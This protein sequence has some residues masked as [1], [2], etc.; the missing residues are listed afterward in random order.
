VVAV[1]ELLL[2]DAQVAVAQPLAGVPDRARHGLD[3]WNGILQRDD[4]GEQLA[5]VLQLGLELLDRQGVRLGLLLLS[6]LGELL[7]A[8]GQQ[9]LEGLDLVERLL[10]LVAQIVDLRLE[11]G[12][13]L[14]TPGE[15]MLEPSG[16][17]LKGAA[18][19]RLSLVQVTWLPFPNRRPQ[20]EEIRCAAL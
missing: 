11:L 10:Q 12:E 1:L 5:A 9:L 7:V 18:E 16:G 17:R 19:L 20:L 8:L 13:L 6:Q 4:A 14:D 2:Q 3:G 15:G